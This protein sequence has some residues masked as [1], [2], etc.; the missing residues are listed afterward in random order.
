MTRLILF[1]IAAISAHVRESRYEKQRISDVTRLMSFELGSS[2][3]PRA[4]E[5]SC[6]MRCSM[7]EHCHF[8][9]AVQSNHCFFVSFG[10]VIGD[11][12]PFDYYIP[13]TLYGKT[14][15]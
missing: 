9:A 10:Q 8:F 1:L 15:R 6:A 2:N 13:E 3:D 12:V 7:H 4:N 5:R 14:D 11:S